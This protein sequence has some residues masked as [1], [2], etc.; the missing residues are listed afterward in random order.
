MAIEGIW[1]HGSTAM[2]SSPGGGGAGFPQFTEGGQMEYVNGKPWTDI[3]GLRGGDGATFHGRTGQQNTFMFS[4]PSPSVKVGP[5][6]GPRTGFR[7]ALIT[8][9]VLYQTDPGVHV[10]QVQPF[11]GGRAF[12]DRARNSVGQVVLPIGRGTGDHSGTDLRTEDA[13]SVLRQGVNM[14]SMP[15]SPTSPVF[16]GL[17]I[18]V[19]VSFHL[20]GTIR[21]A[22]AGADFAVQDS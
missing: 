13:F 2:I 15:T 11:D 22:A 10:T 6:T 16:W 18:L 17:G 3:T 9:Y 1:V 7:A 14:F 19:Q 20:D 5:A 4:I 12:V 8:F 21:F